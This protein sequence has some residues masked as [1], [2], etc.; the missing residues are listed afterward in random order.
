MRHRL[1]EK[2]KLTVKLANLCRF[3]VHVG[4]WIMFRNRIY[5][6]NSSKRKVDI[7]PDKSN[8][9]VFLE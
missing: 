1:T 9:I 3:R 2:R 7:I 8:A 5:T 6:F 4:E